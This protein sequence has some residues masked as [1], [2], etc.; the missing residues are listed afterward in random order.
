MSKKIE[1]ELVLAEEKIGIVIAR[2]N[3]FFT[4]RLLSGARDVLLRHGGKDE[5]I[6]EFWVPGSFEIP[7]AVSKICESKKYSFDGILCLGCLIRGATPHFDF[8]ANEATKGIANVALENK[9]PISYGVIT[10]DNFDQAIERSG[11]KAG[12]KGAESALSLIEMINI[13]KQ[14]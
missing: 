14:L 9:L 2:F 3:E 7:L 6:T 4:S 13:Y 11:T 5:N 12:N 10:V 1:G 8:I